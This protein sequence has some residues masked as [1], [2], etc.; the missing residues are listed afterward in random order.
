MKRALLLFLGVALLYAGLGLL[1]GRT[2]A[3]VDL[4]LDAGAWKPDPAQRVRVSNSLLGDV[5]VQFIPWDREIVR[6]AGRGEMP[7]VNQLAGDGGPLFANPQTVLFSPFTWP[8]LLFGLDGWAIMAILKL[9]AAALCAYWLARELDVPPA[10]ALLS[11]LVYATAGY[12]IVW[13]LYPITHVYTLLPGLGAAALRLMKRPTIHNAALVILFAALCSAGGHPETLFIGVVGIWIFLAWEAEKRP[14]LGLAALIP[15]SV[16]AFLGF[17]LLAFQLLPFLNLLGD[18]YASVLRPSM[19]H[20]FRLWGAASQILP[21]IL[22]TP[23]RGELDLTALPMAENFNMRVGGYIGAIVLLAIILAF[24]DLPSS[25][26]RGLALGTVALVVSWYPPG[27][28]RIARNIPVL[29]VLTLEYLVAL[30]VLFA[31]LAA[32]PAIAIVATRRRRKVGA[33]LALGGTLALLAGVL[34]LIPAAHRPLTSVARTGIDQLRSRG[35][36]HQPPEVYEQRLGYYL[37]AAGLTTARRLAI[38]G[39][40]WL[41]AGLALTLPFRRR[42]LVLATAAACELFAFGLGFNPAVPMTDLPSEPE[43]ITAIKRLD[44]ERRHLIAEHFEIFPANLA[45]LY[46]VRDAI[47]YD[48]MSMKARVTELLP[49]GYDPLLHTFNPILSPEQVQYLSRLGVRFVLSRGPVAGATR[50]AG[51]PEPAVGVHEIPHAAP[52]PLPPNHPPSG[53]I[54]GIVITLLAIL[55]SAVWLRLYLLEPVAM[56]TR[57]RAEV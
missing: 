27:L 40:C 24:R 35:H 17:L 32:G 47:S 8:R 9:L 49:G 23:L 15:S 12:T 31:A 39:A 25:L 36:L 41:L 46:G 11:G 56:E 55:A 21:G 7:W 29:R 43:T 10:Q 37:S 13:L 45:T 50:V 1:P 22:G 52:V 16:G 44:P 4:P 48:A 14:E 57:A 20:P 34:P 53:L 28:W 3:P 51:P 30:F 2:F 5:V 19:P 42:E 54:T 18:S 26:K 38:P 6:M 33:A